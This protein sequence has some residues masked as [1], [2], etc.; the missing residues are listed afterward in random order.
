M[1]LSVA[2]W[3][4]TMSDVYVYLLQYGQLPAKGEDAMTIDG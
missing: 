4:T 3:A 1:C 2:V